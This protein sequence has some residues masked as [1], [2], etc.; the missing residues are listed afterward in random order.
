M[1][2]KKTACN[3]IDVKNKVHTFLSWDTSHPY[4]EEIYAELKRLEGR[5][6]DAEYV[7]NTGS[8]FHD[9]EDEKTGMILGSQRKVGSCIWIDQHSAWN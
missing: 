4:S 1:T 9:V 8:V 6:E 5:M 7:P 2:D 3:W